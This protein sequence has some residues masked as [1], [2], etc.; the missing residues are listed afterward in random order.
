MIEFMHDFVTV[1]LFLLF[2]CAGIAFVVEVYD[3]FKNPEKENQ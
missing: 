1:V 2:V 3:R